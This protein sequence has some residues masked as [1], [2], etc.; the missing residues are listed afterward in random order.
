M[1]YTH[2]PSKQSIPATS[3]ALTSH[4]R[5]F[6]RSHGSCLCDYVVQHLSRYLTCGS[7]LH[8]AN[9]IVGAFVLGWGLVSKMYVSSV[10][11]M[12][13]NDGI[14][15]HISFG[16]SKTLH[17]ICNKNFLGDQDRIVE[18]FCPMLLQRMHGQSIEC[19]LTSSLRF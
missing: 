12:P 15:K 7:P 19:L 13:E 10:T 17:D 9:Q 4:S 6:P 14:I 5:Y 8:T 18:Q 3:M 1:I 11:I 16:Y 2:C